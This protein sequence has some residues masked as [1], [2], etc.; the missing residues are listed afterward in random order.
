LVA[1]IL[2]RTNT[3]PTHYSYY[4]EALWTAY[5]LL[6]RGIP[7]IASNGFLS[8]D[9]M[10]VNVS[11]AFEGYVREL[12]ADEVSAPDTLVVDGNKQPGALFVDTAGFNIKPDVLVRK[13]GAVLGVLD[14]KYKPAPKESDR[15]E[16]LSYLDA[17][18][19]TRGAFICP[20]TNPQ[21]LS[22]YLGRTL[23]GKELALIRID[24]A[25]S[26]LETE[27]RR[28]VRNVQKFLGGNYAFE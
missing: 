12:I 7:D 17:I 28:F 16:V 13:A 5:A 20:A 2:D 15:Y 10:I 26:N 24:L 27:E 25:A 6:Q 1:K 21:E 23:T 8:L 11:E 4:K 14:A 22:Q 9:S 18:K 19:A 3:I